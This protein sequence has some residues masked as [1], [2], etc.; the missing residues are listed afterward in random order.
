MAISQTL[1]V[2]YRSLDELKPFANNPRIHPRRQIDQL[3]VS[4][5]TFGFTN[6]ILV[7]PELNIIA[8]H[9]RLLAARQMGLSSVPTIA[10]RGMTPA[11]QRALR[12]ADNKI[13]LNGGWDTDLLRIELSEIAAD[14]ALEDLGFSAGELNVVLSEASDPDD[15]VVPDLPA[16]AISQPGD[17]WILGEH[18][19]GCGDGRA[20]GF[21]LEVV[22]PDTAVD[23]AFLDP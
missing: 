22:G 20:L 2:T 11:Q 18:R 19:I 8:G 14:I 5:T 6:P 10:L 3:V 21:L 7:D 9:G 4:L 17:I 23:A 1:E 15:E 16:K 12:I 13:M